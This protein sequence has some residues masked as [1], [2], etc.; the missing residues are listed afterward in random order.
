MPRFCNIVVGVDLSHADRL[1]ASELNPPTQEAVR[2]A[3][4]LSAQLSAKLTFFSAIDLL[5]MDII[6]RSGISG[7]LIGNTV[8]RLLP[9]VFCSVLALKPDDF[10]CPIQPK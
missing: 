2:R 5:V 7:A 3:I 6:A 9:H 1:A 10:Q 4:W 8:E